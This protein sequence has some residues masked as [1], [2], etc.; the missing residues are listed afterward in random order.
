LPNQLNLEITESTLNENNVVAYHVIDG[1]KNMGV[2]LSLSAFG[3]GEASLSHLNRLP[4]DFLKIDR[5][6]VMAM[7]THEPSRSMVM[8]VL[9]MA[10]TLD[11]DVVADGI[12][13]SDTLGKLRAAQCKFV[14]GNLISTAKSAAFLEPM[15]VRRNY[16]SEDMLR[17][18]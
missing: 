7:D 14:Q 18:S 10:N 13:S 9:A 1:L 15:L 3:T 2:R 8:S 6:F 17:L 5:S 11:I 4:I 12:D 16:K